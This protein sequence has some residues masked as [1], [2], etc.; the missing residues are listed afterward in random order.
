MITLDVNIYWQQLRQ[1]LAAE[2]LTR[3]DPELGMRDW[4]W[5]THACQ[6]DLG[7]EASQTLQFDNESDAV[8]FVLRWS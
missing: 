2:R 3:D 4:L 7:R 8:L 1:A 5:E 6:L